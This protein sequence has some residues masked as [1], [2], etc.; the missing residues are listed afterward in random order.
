MPFFPGVDLG[1]VD[2]PRGDAFFEKQGEAG[3]LVNIG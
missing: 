3:S 1:F 2:V